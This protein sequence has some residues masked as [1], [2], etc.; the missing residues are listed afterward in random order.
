MS[1]YDY[2]NSTIVNED[3]DDTDADEEED[4]EVEEEDFGMEDGDDD[5]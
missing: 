3:W 5:M 4:D 2:L 1:L